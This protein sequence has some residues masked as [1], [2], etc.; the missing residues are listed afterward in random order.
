[1]RM[2]QQKPFDECKRVFG[3]RVVI[4]SNSAGSNDDPEFEKAQEIEEQLQIAVLKHNQ[5]VRRPCVRVAV[6]VCPASSS[7]CHAYRNR[8]ALST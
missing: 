6:V 2:L 8:A 1:M 5:K 4:F 3:D 7:M